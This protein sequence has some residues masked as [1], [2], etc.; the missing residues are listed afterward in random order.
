MKS[1]TSIDKSPNRFI[2][3]GKKSLYPE[4]SNNFEDRTLFT[5]GFSMWLSL[6]ISN[7]AIVKIAGHS[8]EEHSWSF[9]D[10]VK[11]FMLNT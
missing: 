5:A 3:L 9:P 7:F 6:I 8:L 2:D 10:R 1:K 11:I 4:A